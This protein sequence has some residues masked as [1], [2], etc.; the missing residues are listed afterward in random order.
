MTHKNEVCRKVILTQCGK[1]TVI[2]SARSAEAG[3]IF[4][5]RVLHEDGRRVKE[6]STQYTWS[7]TSGETEESAIDKVIARTV[8]KYE[9]ASQSDIARINYIA[10]FNALSSEEQK[11]L[12]PLEWRA[13]ST[14]KSA[15][16][17]YH[18]N[19]LPIIQKLLDNNGSEESLEAAQDAFL[20]EV[21]KHQGKKDPADDM[22]LEY[23]KK[24]ANRHIYEA[25]LLYEASRPLFP[26]HNLIPLRIPQYVTSEIIPAEQC[27]A[28][29]RDILVQLAALFRLDLPRTPLAAG[30]II[31]LCSMTRT[32][33][34]CPRFGEVV[35]CGDYGVYTVLTQTNGAVRVKRLKRSS[36]SR[37]IIL[38]RFAMDAIRERCALLEKQ[39][40]SQDEIERSFIV[41]RDS[42]P[43][44]PASPQELSRYIREKMELLGTKEDFWRAVSL[45]AE[46]APDLD[47]YGNR[48][49]D[50]Q[51]YILRRSG[52][53]YLVNCTACPA[54]GTH[55]GTAPAAL[56]DALM[57]H[58]LSPGD[59]DWS[60]WIRRDDNWPLIAQMMESI[61][62][63][64]DHSAH[65]AFNEK[66][67][68]RQC[69][70]TQVCH[71]V[72]RY[73]VSRAD[74]ERGEITLQ[75]R[76]Q[77]RDNVLLKIP[78]GVKAAHKKIPLSREHSALP[79][80]NEI[81]PREYYTKLIQKAEELNRN[82]RK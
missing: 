38:P 18:R 77:T 52:C 57:G 63:D 61:I 3:K 45:L 22:L 58:K 37:A 34:T 25:N 20:Q 62:L 6:M 32:A 60:G 70:E 67:T 46:A 2:V 42:D 40:L 82:G 56:V 54:V 43:F 13:E 48:L 33:E 30:A 55:A 65:P 72:Q 21:I 75:I 7:A 53:T 69:G 1:I 47:E 73:L 78:H 4:S 50:L 59:A 80:V 71:A 11:R 8:D 44:T 24:Q 74:M 10:M 68:V 12:C 29:P 39:G 64:P 14:K 81:L 23:A 51:A 16:T 76:C 26:Q 27:K 5:A 41:S 49:G 36:S 66:S 35:D 79:T 28:L 19:A 9:S 15:L 17:Y 31:M